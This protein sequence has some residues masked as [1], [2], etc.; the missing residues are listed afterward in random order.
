MSSAYSLVRRSSF[1]QGSGSQE[2][3]PE[4]DL[5]RFGTNNEYCNSRHSFEP[6]LG[7]Q[8]QKIFNVYWTVVT[9]P[10]QTWS[11]GD[12]FGVKIYSEN[13]VYEYSTTETSNN[14]DGHSFSIHTM[15]LMTYGQTLSFR[16]V[17][18]C[19]NDHEFLARSDCFNLSL[20][21]L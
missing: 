12:V 10:G 5:V 21:S 7:V 1:T 16:V 20:I 2:T 18:N 11:T 9:P 4:F 8:E 13:Y 6:M 14:T 19:S 15:F 3:D 17:S